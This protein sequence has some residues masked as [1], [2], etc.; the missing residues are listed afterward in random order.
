MS[1]S[2]LV[3]KSGTAKFA[4]AKPRER[5]KKAILLAVCGLAV[6][7]VNGLFGAGG[8]MLAVPV[9]TF[10]AGLGEK[11]AHATAIA[12]ILPLCLVSTVV[13][14]VR[15]TFDYSVLPPTIA[16]VL[17]GGQIAEHTNYATV[18]ATACVLCAVGYLIFKFKTA[19]HFEKHKLR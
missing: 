16:G 17:I 15:G 14:A 18:Y 8:G 2:V 1:Y 12:V 3:S 10:A 13:Y 4:A 19:A 5:K 11:K 9:L 6:G 7:A